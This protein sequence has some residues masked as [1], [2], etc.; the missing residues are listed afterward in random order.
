M[1]DWCTKQLCSSSSMIGVCDGAIPGF[2][3]T[4]TL[5]AE[6][7]EWPEPGRLRLVC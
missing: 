3:R 7:W 6:S 1:P 2:Q 5:H 4:C